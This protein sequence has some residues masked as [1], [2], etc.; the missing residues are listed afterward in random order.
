MERTHEYKKSRSYT[1]KDGSV[2]YYDNKVKYKAHPVIETIHSGMAYIYLKLQWHKTGYGFSISPYAVIKKDEGNDNMVRTDKDSKKIMTPVYTKEID[3]DIRTVCKSMALQNKLHS[4]QNFVKK[5]GLYSEQEIS[6]QESNLVQLDCPEA[7]RDILQRL[8]A[9]RQTGN[10][11]LMEN[12]IVGVLRKLEMYYAEWDETGIKPEGELP[13]FDLK[14]KP[15]LEKDNRTDEE[16]DKDDDLEHARTTYAKITADRH[17]AND[18]LDKA[19]MRHIKDVKYR[20]E[21]RIN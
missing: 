9:L 7:E 21:H 15:Q 20:A 12:E 8:W 2:S 16:K 5:N 18:E 6:V 14:L 10:K 3:I 4:I 17:K 19:L 1:K 11:H 13:E